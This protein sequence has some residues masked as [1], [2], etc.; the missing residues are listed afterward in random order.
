M[1]LAEWTGEGGE[2]G[3]EVGC[4]GWGFG[5]EHGGSLFRRVGLRLLLKPVCSGGRWKVTGDAGGAR[6]HRWYGGVIYAAA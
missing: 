1:T 2:R 5:G 3:D 6:R 4:E